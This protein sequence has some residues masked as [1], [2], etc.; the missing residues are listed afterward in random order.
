LIEEELLLEIVD[1]NRYLWENR[2][3][4]NIVQAWLNNFSGEVAESSDEHSIAI[5]LLNNFLYYGEKEIKY[6]CRAAFSLLKRSQVVENPLPY[7]APAAGNCNSEFIKGCK[8]SYIGRAGE[9]GA[10][11]L[12]YFR[13]ENRLSIEQFADPSAFLTSEVSDTELS[14]CNLVFID[15]FL[16]TGRTACD[17][18]NSKIV[19]IKERCPEAKL[20]YLALLATTSA[21]DEVKIRTGLAVICPQVLD[22]S[23]RV[24]SETSSIFPERKKRDFAKGV[25]GF[26]GGH[27]TSKPHAL[28]YRNSQALLGFHH[29]IPDNT[30]PIIWSEAEL[31]NNK[32][33]HPLFKRE[34]KF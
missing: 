10:L 1:R 14:R 5:D 3:T 33:W 12:Y 32:K 19:A 7:V 8:F 27:L 18:W 26:Y 29:N 21:L 23:H 2:L 31:Q 22:D 30:L 20:H 28:G 9:S 4:K 17:F 6:L 25:C 24:F 16:G 13:Q 11:V 34:Q 15:D